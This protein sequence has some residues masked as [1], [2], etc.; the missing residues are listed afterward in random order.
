MMKDGG[1]RAADNW[2]SQ[3]DGNRRTR[4]DKR[5][6]RDGHRAWQLKAIRDMTTEVTEAVRPRIASG[7]SWRRRTTAPSDSERR[8]DI[9]HGMA[10]ADEPGRSRDKLEL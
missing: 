10:D 6:Q 4:K 5:A 1:E 9:K 2:G 8:E 7:A 3:K